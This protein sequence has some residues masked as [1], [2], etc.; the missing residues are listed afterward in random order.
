MNAEKLLL[1]NYDPN[2]DPILGDDHSLNVLFL[3]SDDR[4]GLFSDEEVLQ[5]HILYS[6]I[7]Q[8]TKLLSFSNVSFIFVFYHSILLII[9][10]VLILG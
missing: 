7:S 6:L 5:F 2:I 9:N 1:L 10:H 4:I 8:L 3:I